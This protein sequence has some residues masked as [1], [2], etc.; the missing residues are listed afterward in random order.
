MVSALTAYAQK[1]VAQSTTARVASDAGQTTAASRDKAGEDGAAVLDPVEISADAQARLQADAATNAARSTKVSYLEQFRP[2]REGFSAHNM[3]LGMVDPGAQPFSK[4]RPFAEVTQAA[5]DELDARYQQMRDS[6][7]PF[8]K[9][10]YEG[11]DIYSLYGNL[12]R[13][14]L[15]AVASN[16]GGHFTRDEQQ[17]AR[18]IMRGQQGMAMGLYNGPTRLEDKFA[19]P[20]LINHEKSF[21]AGVQF[22]DQ[23]SPEEKGGDVEWAVQRANMQNVY[24]DQA[25]ANGN[26][27]QDFTIDHPLM[28]LIRQALDAWKD[29]P[30]LTSNGI[31]QN[32]DDLRGQSWFKD[33]AVRLDSAIA[34][35]RNLYGLAAA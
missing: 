15:E 12:D 20:A 26:P 7:Q 17:Q 3:A 21:K 9:D 32:A 4:D 18:D 33:Y 28:N 30:G 8:D 29:H 2:T 19:N 23:V 13:R 6:G 35:T 10:S 22:M 14:A 24:E 16:A 31:I 34:D 11:V 27:P 5:R 1:Y 25:R